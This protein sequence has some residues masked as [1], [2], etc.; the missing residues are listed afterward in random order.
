MAMSLKK[1]AVTGPTKNH[2]TMN[3]IVLSFPLGEKKL[4]FP[5]LTNRAYRIVETKQ[6][7]VGVDFGAGR[8]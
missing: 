3:D 2:G 4:T 5:P 8:P 1:E 6:Q 7:G